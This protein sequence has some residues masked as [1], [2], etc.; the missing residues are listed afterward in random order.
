MSSDIR[1]I[2]R[3]KMLHKPHILSLFPNLFNKFNKNMST[4]VRS[5]ISFILKSYLPVIL[6]SIAQIYYIEDL[7]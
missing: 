3:D 6:P 2:K 7:T 1:H 5:S 4:H